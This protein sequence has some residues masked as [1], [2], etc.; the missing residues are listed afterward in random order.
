MNLVS[1][2]RMRRSA[3][4]VVRF[5]VSVVVVAVL[6]S[7]C[8][9]D[10]DVSVLSA[11]DGVA[12]VDG[13]DG[14]SGLAESSG[15]DEVFH[16]FS[17]EV[18]FPVDVWGVA[19]SVR[20]VDVNVRKFR[21]G[22]VGIS[23]SYRDFALELRDGSGSVLHSVGFGLR[24]SFGVYHSLGEEHPDY[25]FYLGR[26][27]NGDLA[28]SRVSLGQ[29]VKSFEVSIKDAPVFDSFAILWKGEEL[30]VVDQSEHAPVVEFS[31]VSGS[32][33]F[34][35]DE[36]IDF[37]VSGEDEDEGLLDFRV[38]YS[39]D[40]GDSYELYD[41]FVGSGVSR[42][43]IDAGGLAGSD[44]AR[45]GISVSDGTNATFVE[46][47]VFSVEEHVP[48]ISFE[49]PTPNIHHFWATG[50]GYGLST[51]VD[52]PETAIRGSSVEVRFHSSID[53][54]LDRGPSSEGFILD[55]LSPGIHTITATATDSSGLSST[56]ATELYVNEGNTPPQAVDDIAHLPIFTPVRF[57]IL[58]NDFDFDGDLR[59]RN[60]FKS[61]F[62]EISKPPRL[63]VARI[64]T[65]QTGE[66]GG[67]YNRQVH[68][69]GGNSGYDF[70]EYRICDVN[71]A[72]DTATV[73]ISAGLGDC[74][75]LGTERDDE[76][77]GTAGDDIICGLGGDDVIRGLG[78]DDIIRAGIG[79]DQVFGGAGD[80]YIRGEMG[81]DVIWGM[82]GDDML[83]GGTGTDV[84]Y[85]GSG[86]DTLG[87]Q[88]EVSTRDETDELYFGDS[89]T[90]TPWE[91]LTPEEVGYIDDAIAE[92][93]RAANGRWIFAEK[94]ECADL[95]L[96]FC[97]SLTTGDDYQVDSSAARRATVDFV[98]LSADMAEQGKTQYEQQ[99]YISDRSERIRAVQEALD[100]HLIL[101][102]NP[103]AV[104]EQTVAKLREL[105]EPVSK[106][107]TRAF[108]QFPML[109]F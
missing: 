78:G 89:K 82:A 63:G 80:D 64:I 46:T 32:Q 9:G 94:S 14:D 4:L 93:Q 54:D 13:C 10:I 17:G 42:F 65:V 57:G 39:F 36:L 16:V 71:L 28:R 2:H 62:V 99:G 8:L 96:G 56:A 40:G 84:I 105:A 20:S 104:S 102:R 30:M 27:E 35:S 50:I 79:D 47:E 1:E 61:T 5:V 29:D 73:Y 44:E 106:C 23:G 101:V 49:F 91:E 3:C 19:P 66:T 25:G 72:C 11:P 67:S 74:T 59:D 55:S 87:G 34:G 21:P 98:C 77:V 6:A 90:A 15:S 100:L 43:V 22:Y 88:D 58:G 85:G 31:G 37:C 52:D 53:G 108:A 60:S 83:L 76:L 18:V 70:L 97:E 86:Y 38:Y 81:D 12:V 45:L 26:M 48:E 33:E 107:T 95:L 69:F 41:E 75:V 109:Y 92:C 103:G 51:R 7:A 24:I 68:Y